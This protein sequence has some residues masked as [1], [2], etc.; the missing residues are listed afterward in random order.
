MLLTEHLNIYD[1]NINERKNK[2]VKIVPVHNMTAY[3]GRRYIAPPTL[4]LVLGEVTG[5]LHAPAALLPE[6]IP[7]PF[8]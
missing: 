7:M 2:K 6:I 4:I 8:Q 3:E 1:K 5:H